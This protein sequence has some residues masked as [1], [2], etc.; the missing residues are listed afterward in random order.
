[1][2]ENI[3]QRAVELEQKSQELAEAN[4]RLKEKTE[5]FERMNKLFADRE[6]RMKELKEEI[7]KLKRNIGEDKT[8]SAGMD[9]TGNENC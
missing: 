3:R 4:V 1:M 9:D 2:E 7:K 5:K 6:L 8:L